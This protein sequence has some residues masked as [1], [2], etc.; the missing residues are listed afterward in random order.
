MYSSCQKEAKSALYFTRNFA[1][2]QSKRL[3]NEWWNILIRMGTIWMYLYVNGFL[4]FMCNAH[5]IH[6]QI[7]I[8]MF[9]E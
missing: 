3:C 1:I 4:T 9:P 7:L 2:E 6:Y 5:S 8:V